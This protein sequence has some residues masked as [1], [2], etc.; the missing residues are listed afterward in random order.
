MVTKKLE[1]KN[2]TNA[3]TELLAI[4]DKLDAFVE[5]SKTSDIEDSLSKL[6]QAAEKVGKA[7]C[8]SNLGYHA[9]V[10]YDG[11]Q[12][13]PAGAN[14]SPEW[15]LMDS[16]SR[17]TAGDWQ[18][19]NSDDVKEAVHK[20][21]ENPNLA[22]AE[23]ASEEAKKL[24]DIEQAEVVSILLNEFSENEDIFIEKLKKEAAEEIGY[25][26]KGE[27]IRRILPSRQR[28]TRDSTAATQGEQ[29]PPHME[30]L[31]EALSLEQSAKACAAL[32]KIARKAGSHITRIKR[33]TKKSE[34]IGTNIFIGHG[35]SHAW[36]DLKDFVKDRLNLPYDEFN[37]IPV[38]GVTNIARLSEMLDSAAIAFLV[39]TAE[40]EQADGNFH[41]RMNVVHESGLFQGKLG[42][43]KAI[44]I[45]EKGCKE[46]SNIQG[47]GQIRFP[48]GN[49]SAV[50]EEIRMVLERENIIPEEKKP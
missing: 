13:P 5:K 43:T 29:V 10:Y 26:S 39:M 7:W 19:W 9:L 22:Q 18:K 32:S 49:I 40:D 31:A 11:L 21:A 38:A 34:M 24:F 4:A 16:F 35:K 45:L 3:A 12:T 6:E 30:V 2:M 37:R 50:F 8:G 36:R 46:F 27:I 14:F 41:A 15:G 28:L 42:F 48:K 23:I 44:V 17:K 47:L 1:S 20:L 33:K 25:L